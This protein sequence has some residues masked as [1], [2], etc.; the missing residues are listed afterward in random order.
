M[1]ASRGHREDVRPCFTL[2]VRG[3]AFRQARKAPAPCPPCTSLRSTSRAWLW[4]TS[5]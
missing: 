5:I 2:D 1:T 3:R 4:T